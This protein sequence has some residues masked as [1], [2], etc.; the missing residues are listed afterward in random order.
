MV[1]LLD[2]HRV[3]FSFKINNRTCALIRI[4][5]VFMRFV[6]TS[7]MILSFQVMWGCQKYI[8][9]NTF[10]KLIFVNLKRGLKLLMYVIRIG[11][12]SNIY[13]AAA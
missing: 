11:K 5:R 4:P 6:C 1:L 13:L 2:Q 7:F 12:S 10:A 8:K 9:E 3:D